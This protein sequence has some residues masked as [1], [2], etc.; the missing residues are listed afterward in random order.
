[1]LTLAGVGAPVAAQTDTPPV[2]QPRLPNVVLVLVEGLGA[3]DLGAHGQVLIHT[4]RLDELASQAVRFT[5]FHTGGATDVDSRAVLMT[6]RLLTNGLAVRVPT[7]G[8]W[9]QKAGYHTGFIGQWGLGSFDSAEAA[10]RRGFDEFA[11]YDSRAHAMDL[12]T[13][14]LYRRDPTTGFEGRV[15]L[16]ENAAGKQNIYLPGLLT[17]A[18]TQF[19][20]NNKPEHLNRFQPFFLVVSYPSP[21]AAIERG[22]ALPPQHLYAD[23]SWP[24]AQKA[25]ALAITWLDQHVG[26]IMDQLERLGLARDTVLIFTSV[27]GPAASPACDLAFFKSAGPFSAG[28]GTLNQGNLRVPLIVRWPFWMKTPQARDVLCGAQDLVPTLLELSRLSVPEG[29]EGISLLPAVLGQA[30]TNRHA[31]LHW[32]ATANSAQQAFRVGNWKV[33][34]RGG[35]SAIEVYDLANDPRETHDLAAVAPA[36]MRRLLG[37]PVNASGQPQGGGTTTA[38]SGPLPGPPK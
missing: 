22:F 1:M 26:E 4:P 11:G 10:H 18:A 21:Q 6:G 3:G 33:L 16:V 19:F 29:M 25:K 23:R 34:C 17:R 12:Y 31:V 2:A 36:L 8:E 30:Q 20:K 9:M 35:H 38:A 13:D 37:W 28:Q 14:G 24:D 15:P 27:T 32:P 7:L 5:D